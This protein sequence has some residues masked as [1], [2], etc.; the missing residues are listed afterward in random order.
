V[1]D[2]RE[3]EI[4]VGWGRLAAVASGDPAGKNLLCL[5]GWMDNA[6]S[7]APLAE[8]L[9]Q[10]RWVALDYAGHGASDHRPEAAHYY[11]T[12]YLFDLDAVLDDL[13]WDRCTL[14]SHSLG[15]GIAACYAC[16]DP[17]RVERIA[18]LDGIGV[19]TEEPTH[20]AQRLTRSLHSVRHPRDHRRVFPSIG[21]AARARQ[22]KNPMADASARL[23]AERALREVEGGWRWRTDPR[24]MWDSPYWMSEAHA[25]NLL[26]G[27]KCPVLVVVTPFLERYLGDRLEARLDALDDVVA[28]RVDGG[29]HL[30]M[31]A[32]E[33][34]SPA[35]LDFL[36]REDLQHD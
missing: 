22:L 23:L 3:L 28:L 33:R 1:S 25:L 2:R 14:V 4:D 35:L 20:A 34:F 8:A 24:A 18:M 31:D 5:H 19:V 7:F 11:F 16:A 13:G 32:P 21:L 26:K 27:V 29:H 15:T 10:F 12:D 17:Q 36:T 30:H 9:P 6:A